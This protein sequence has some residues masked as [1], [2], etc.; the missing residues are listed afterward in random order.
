MASRLFLCVCSGRSGTRTYE[1]NL[2]LF[3]EVDAS[4]EVRS[5][6]PL[7]PGCTFCSLFRIVC[8][9]WQATKYS[10]RPRDVHFHIMKKDRDAEFWPRLL[11]D[12]ALEKTN[13]KLDWDRY[14]DE[15]GEDAAGF[16]TDAMGPGAMVRIA[17]NHTPIYYLFVCNVLR[18]TLLLS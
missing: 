2:E 12:K 5:L 16:D 15:D 13:V 11:K 18:V 8:S 3:A 1:C 17:F 10:V 4:D 6:P 9:T 14:V 7:L